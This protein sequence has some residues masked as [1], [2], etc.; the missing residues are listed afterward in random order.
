[1]DFINEDF[2]LQHIDGIRSSYLTTRPQ[3]L[4]N[5]YQWEQW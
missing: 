4:H 5:R 3:A 2:D 1:M